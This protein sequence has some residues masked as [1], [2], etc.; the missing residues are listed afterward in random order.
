MILH[1]GK[2]LQLNCVDTW[3]YVE[4]LTPFIP[5][6]VIAKKESTNEILIVKQYRPP[7]DGL[8]YEFP[9]G[10]P[11]VDETIEDAACREVL[12]ETGYTLNRE[13]VGCK[14]PFVNSP[15]MSAEKVF[16]C[17]AIIDESIPQINQEL[18]Q[19][20]ETHDLI[21][22]LITPTEFVTKYLVGQTQYLMDPK[23]AEYMLAQ[24]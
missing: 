20:E 3:E 24:N 2:H 13:S 16:R 23:L 19:A 12:E 22:F 9:A 10:F 18:D 14:G 17:T 4:R 7:V 21:S 5:V 11:E 8:V 1:T 6:F 15:G